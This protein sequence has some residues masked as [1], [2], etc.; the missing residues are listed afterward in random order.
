VLVTHQM[1]QLPEGG[2]R[3]ASQHIAHG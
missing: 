3:I 2:V 1:D